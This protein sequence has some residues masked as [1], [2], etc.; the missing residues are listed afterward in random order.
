MSEFPTPTASSIPNFRD[1]GGH[2]TVEGARVR[3]GLLY[4]SVALDE[5]SDEALRLLSELG[6]RTV[7]DLRTSMEQEH[8]PDRLPD[9]TRHMSVDLLADSGEAD[10]AELFALMQDP[11]RASEELRDGGTQRFYVATYHD[12][13]RLPSARAGYSRLLR[14]LADP[15]A[16]PALVHCTTGKD[17]TGWAVALLLLYLG[18]SEA[19]VMEEYL[20]SDAEVRGAFSHV[21]DDFVARGGE[22]DVIEPLMSVQPAFL[23][24]ALTA[25]RTDHGTIE[26]YVH[27]GLGLDAATGAALRAAFLER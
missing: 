12:L 27:D 2:E 1:A 5:P 3:T 14:T 4:R 22:H 20:A 23:E 7:F 17:R 16:R 13:V 25:M 8:K 26:A 21:I 11:V 24:A 18:V 9:G 10:P 19:D 15:R 6:V